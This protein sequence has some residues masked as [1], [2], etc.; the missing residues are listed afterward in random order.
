MNAYMRSAFRINI[1]VTFAIAI[2]AI[3]VMDVVD[4]RAGGE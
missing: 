2:I 3:M 4:H 1:V